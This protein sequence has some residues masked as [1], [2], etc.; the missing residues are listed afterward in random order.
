MI[1]NEVW[2]HR[3]HCKMCGIPLQIPIHIPMGFYC[4]T[5]L[6]ILEYVWKRDMKEAEQK[7]KEQQ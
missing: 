6:K 4:P 7:A 2:L 3:L 1:S 5:C